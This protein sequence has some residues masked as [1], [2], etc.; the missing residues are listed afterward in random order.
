MTPTANDNMLISVVKMP[1][2]P[3]MGLGAF[4]SGD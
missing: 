3:K 2:G 4:G 1:P